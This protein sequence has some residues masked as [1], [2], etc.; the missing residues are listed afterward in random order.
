MK[1]ILTILGIFFI[2][3]AI[4]SILPYFMDYSQLSEYGKGFIWGKVILFF[5]GLLLIYAGA[6][7]KRND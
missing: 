7:R 4:I 1:K 6:W 5:A 2:L 3:A